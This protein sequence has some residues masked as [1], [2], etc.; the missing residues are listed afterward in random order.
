M[1]VN[2]IAEIE[3][4][5]RFAYG[6]LGKEPNIPSNATILYTVEL[7]SSELEA[8]IETLNAN[9]RKEIGY[10][11]FTLLLILKFVIDYCLFFKAIK[12]ENVGIGGLLVMNQHLQFNVTGEL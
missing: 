11:F 8:E 10:L 4:D 1:D 9:Q 2:E 6:S 5:P 12:N 3:V 7:K